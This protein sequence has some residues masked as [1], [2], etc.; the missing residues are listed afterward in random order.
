MQDTITI[1]QLLKKLILSCI[2][3][4]T[5][6]FLS[7]QAIRSYTIELTCKTRT[8][9]T[10]QSIV[11][12]KWHYRSPNASGQYVFR[13]N[14]E[15]HVWGNPYRILGSRDS[16]FNDTIITG[17]AFEYMV[18]KD[19]GPDGVPIFGFAY[20]GHKVNAITN[21]GKILLVIDSTN[22]SFLENDIRTFR[23]DL[24]G[25][26]WNTIVKWVSPSTTVTQVKSY[27]VSQY[28]ADPVNVKSVVLIGDIAVP[29]SGDYEHYSLCP[30][31]DG[32]TRV[33]GYGPSH[34]GAWPTDLYYGSMSPS[35][36]KD[37]LVNNTFGVRPANRNIPNDGKFDI[38]ELKSFVQLQ[39]GRIDLSNMNLFKNDVADT[40]HVE[41]EL[42]KRYFNKNHIFK[43]KLVTIKERCLLD[44]NFGLI[45]AGGIYEHFGTSSYRNMAPLIADS[46]VK[47]LNYLTELNTK[48]YLWSF[49][50]GDGTYLSC[51]GIGTTS[52]MAAS[53][54]SIKSVFTGLMGSF[55][56][57][58]DTANNFLRAPLAAKGNVLNSFWT[59]RPH[60]YFH[61]MG[62][63][64]TIGYSALKTQN[65]YDSALSQFYGWALT[66]YP[67]TYFTY[68]SFQ[69]HSSLM[70]DPS[71]RMQVV[72]PPSNLLAKQ[73]SCNLAVKLTWIAPSDTAVN[74]YYVYRSKHIDSTFTQIGT[75]SNL[76]WKDNAPLSGNNVYMIRAS[77]LQLSGSGTYYNLSQGIFD[78]ISSNE[79]NT[80]L[81]NAGRDTNVC[82]NSIVKLGLK[83]NS[84]NTSYSWNLSGYTRDTVSIKVTTSNNWILTATDTISTCVK[85]DSINIVALSL[86]LSE[87]ITASNLYCMDTATWSSTS[88]NGIAY[89]Y[90]WHFNGGIPS[91]TSGLGLSSPGQIL[92]SLSG[93]LLGT[94]K[95]INPINNCQNI[96]SQ[97]VNI[98][99]IGLPIKNIEINCVNTI[100]GK[101]ITFLVFDNEQFLSYTIEGFNGKEWKFLATVQAT[102]NR[103]Y[104]YLIESN[105]T[106]NEIKIKG[107]NA[108]NEMIDLGSCG[109]DD[110]KSDWDI[111]PNP[112]EDKFT[113]HYNGINGLRNT[114]I[115]ICDAQGTTIIS[116]VMVLNNGH[117]EMT[118]M[119]YP[120]GVYT[121]SIRTGDRVEVYKL[122]KL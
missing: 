33:S 38:T 109:N 119:G 67:V 78:T 59:G 72:E 65:N 11:E 80:P 118:L 122:I 46:V 83:Y 56:G 87:S 7:G 82:K 100:K 19:N 73:D 55:F 47:N 117:I 110:L 26:G 101:E 49:G 40:A 9:N 103:S 99:C 32:H 2:L 107:R 115:M 64:E 22:K 112:I 39:V 96:D 18:E 69:V 95:V 34:E 113:I 58:W 42:L 54:Q 45:N 116:K 13:K 62:L 24:I 104:Q 105:F 16:S 68:N 25:D 121:L 48:D 14:K 8:Y 88:R 63:G 10:T 41:R 94:L 93:S 91:D 61:H 74:S 102:T 3:F 97:Y 1:F 92:Y 79:L 77:K 57:D 6:N 81:V 120:N 75:S 20:S 30:P 12:F 52:Q 17:K 21:R 5:Y 50:I 4:I 90:T 106:Y 43:H 71:V 36:W 35:T 76:Y 44:D 114:E 29:Y 84:K 23:N 60:W 15:R 51:N 108:L 31:P 37:S 70:G 85:R 98:N 86:P 89:R 28:N 111:F 53:S 27:I 66:I